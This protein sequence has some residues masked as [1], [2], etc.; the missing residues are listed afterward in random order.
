M[1]R[2]QYLLTIASREVSS[3]Y[4]TGEEGITGDEE[5]MIGEIEATAALGVAR[6]VDDGAAQT[7]DG[8]GLA[9]FEVIVG[10]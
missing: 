3:A 6:G 2:P 4:G 8:N 10:G 9:V 5:G 7:D 1:N